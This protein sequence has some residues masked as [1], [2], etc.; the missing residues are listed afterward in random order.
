MEKTNVHPDN[1]PERLKARRKALQLTQIQLAKATEIS[2]KT[3]QKYEYGDTPK[4]PNLLRLSRALN[5]SIDWLL[6]GSGSG[7]ESSELDRA[8]SQKE[9]VE[10][11]LVPKV[12]ARLDSDGVPLEKSQNNKHMYAFRRVWIEQKGDPSQMVL[13]DVSGDSMSPEVK[14]GDTVLIDRSQTEIYIGKIY[15][16]SIGKEITVRYVERAPGRIILRCANK[17]WSDIGVD[18]DKDFGEQVGIIGRVVWWC[19]DVR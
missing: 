18:I 8:Y 4:G 6:L 13:M 1:F 10:L 5:C 3:I 17:T 15:A 19:R 7:S 9:H 16:V 12:L 14:D 2:S 11:T